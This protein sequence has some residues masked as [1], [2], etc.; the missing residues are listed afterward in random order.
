[1]WD[2]LYKDQMKT[3]PGGSD[4]SFYLNKNILIFQLHILCYRSKH[5]IQKISCYGR[6][7]VIGTM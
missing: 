5:F 4:T 6:K 1:M 3:N 2:L 7:M